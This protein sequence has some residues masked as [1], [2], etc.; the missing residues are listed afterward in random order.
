MKKEDYLQEISKIMGYIKAMN[1]LSL[2]DENK[3]LKILLEKI[4][5]QHNDIDPGLLDAKKAFYMLGFG[6][7]E[8]KN[9][10]LWS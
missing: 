5:E 3:I 6:L 7:A 1:L 4:S 10:T 9:F 8:Y 2:N